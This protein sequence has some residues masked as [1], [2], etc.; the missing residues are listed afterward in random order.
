MFD[1][2]IQCVETKFKRA[3]KTF[4]VMGRGGTNFHPVCEYAQ[5]ERIDGLIIYTDGMAQAPPKPKNTKVL[6]LM[7]NKDLRP[8]VE[9]GMV[10]CLDRYEDAH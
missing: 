6:W 9:W 3:R 5:K 2:E 7:T 8:P 10:A 1:W 4:K